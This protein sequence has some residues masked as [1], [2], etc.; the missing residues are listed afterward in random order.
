[1][2]ALRR[3]WP[4][5][6]HLA[7][8]SVMLHARCAEGPVLEERSVAVPRKGPTLPVKTT[9]ATHTKPACSGFLL[10]RCFFGHIPRSLIPNFAV[11]AGLLRSPLTLNSGS[12]LWETRTRADQAERPTLLATALGTRTSAEIAGRHSPPLLGQPAVRTTCL[13]VPP[14]PLGHQM[15]EDYM[16]MK[17]P[18]EKAE[19]R[20]ERQGPGLP[21]PWSELCLRPRDFLVT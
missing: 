20:G 15:D 19:P 8:V 13:P 11:Q 1:M 2:D 4:S 12:L 21:R 18:Q 5:H 7:L 17:L 16:K 10:L 9:T 14:G 6:R 3:H